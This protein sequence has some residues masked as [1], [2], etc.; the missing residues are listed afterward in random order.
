MTQPTPKVIRCGILDC[1]WGTPFS[2]LLELNTTRA[3]S[4][5]AGEFDQRSIC[6]LS[7]QRDMRPR[8]WLPL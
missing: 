5:E 6:K 3:L 4:R 8:R 1:D 7:K 2:I